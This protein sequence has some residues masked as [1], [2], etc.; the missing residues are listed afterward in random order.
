MTEAA[1]YRAAWVRLIP[2]MKQAHPPY[3]PR[4]YAAAVTSKR[5]TR[6]FQPGYDGSLNVL[7]GAQ[8]PDRHVHEN[9]FDPGAP[10]EDYHPGG[11]HGAHHNH[12]NNPN[13][14]PPNDPF[15]RREVR[16]RRAEVEEMMA[17]MEHPPRRRRHN[18]GQVVGHP[19]ENIAVGRPVF[20]PGLEAN[21]IPR[22]PRGD[23]EARERA[24]H[25]ANFA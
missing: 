9:P 25:R 20:Q 10:H 17:D 4:S 19:P 2:G 15:N 3:A 1:H 8:Y 12:H 14:I 5:F 24:I 22:D 21:F 18:P 16:R 11:G 13:H 23:A 6:D 7:G